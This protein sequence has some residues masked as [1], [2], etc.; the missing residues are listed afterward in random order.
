MA[1]NSSW[2]SFRPIFLPEWVFGPA[3]TKQKS[4]D[5]RITSQW[6]LQNL[7]MWFWF[8]FW[9]NSTNIFSNHL[10]VRT[11]WA[12][13]VPNFFWTFENITVSPQSTIKYFAFKVVLSSENTDDPNFSRSYDRSVRTILV[14]RWNE[15]S[16]WVKMRCF[17]I[18]KDESEFI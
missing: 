7:F 10:Q 6:I 3:K 11:N 8:N 18:V 13:L 14:F 2:I 4:F 15:P 17:T 12:C 5:E 16:D 9:M 1:Y